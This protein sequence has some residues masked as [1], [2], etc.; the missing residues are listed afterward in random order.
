MKNVMFTMWFLDFV[1]VFNLSYNYQN[2]HYL[3]R[4]QVFR[5]FLTF[6]YYNS[7]LPCNFQPITIQHCSWNCP[8]VLSLVEIFPET[9]NFVLLTC[10]CALERRKKPDGLTFRLFGKTQNFSKFRLWQ[11]TVS[12]VFGFCRAFIFWWSIKTQ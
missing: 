10:T 11:S 12:V 7:L 8:A 5:P 3:C 9:R 6:L 1:T 2:T 4:N